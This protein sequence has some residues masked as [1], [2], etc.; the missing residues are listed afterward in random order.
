[1]PSVTYDRQ[2]FFVD[3][4]RFWVLGASI[5]YSRVPPEL[6]ARRI[7]AARQAG[8]N[9][10][11][12]ACPWM[13]HEPRKGRFS[14]QGET[15]VRRFVQTCGE[16][17]MRVILR[18]GPYVGSQFDGGGLPSWLM[19]LPNVAAREA[20][21]PFLERVARY[22]R[23]LF[24]ELSDLQATKGQP[25]LLVQSEHAWLCSHPRQAERYLREITRIIRESGINVPIISAN[26][27]WPEPDGT[28]DTWRGW[29]DLLV[30]LRQLRTVQ[31]AAPRLV[32]AFD[33]AG[34]DTW[35]VPHRHRKTASEVM[36]RLA[37]VLA[38]GAQVVVSPFHGGTNFGF[39]AGRVAGRSDGFVTTAAAAGAPLGE[40]GARGEKYYAVR[41]LM[42]FANHFSH[43]FAE[44][45]PDYHP[46]ALDLAELAAGPAGGGR[47][48]AKPRPRGVSIVSQSGSQG[49][50]VF[51]FGDGRLRSTALLLEDGIRMPVFFGDQPV[52][53][54]VFGV[55]LRGAGRLDYANLC[56]WAIVGRSIVVLYGPQRTGVFLSVNGAPLEATVP[57]GGKPL[58]LEH[59]GVTFVMCN[60]QQIDQTYHDDESVYV[61][62]GGID[63]SGAPIPLG[64][65]SEKAWVIGTGGRIES[66]DLGPPGGGR[67]S[68]RRGSARGA[69]RSTAFREWEAASAL[70][71]AR[72]ESPRYATLD[73]PETLT[74]CGAAAGYGW[75]RIQIKSGS[76]RKRLC[77][78]PHGGDR[79]HFFVDGEL[80]RVFGVGPGA[81]HEPFEL[82][83]SKGQ[84]TIVVLAESLGRFAEG[85]D[86]A[87]R[88]G[89]YG[90]LYEVKRLRTIRPKIGEGDPVDPFVLRGYLAHRASG[91][92]SDTTQVKWTFVHTRKTPILVDIDGAA[93]SGTFVLN[94]QPVAYYAGATGGC[95]ARLLL[96][97][98]GT[99]AFRRGRNVLRFAPDPRQPGAPEEL[100]KATAIYE[101]TETLTKA[102]SWGF[103][104]W[105]A[106]AAS[107][108]SPLGKAAAK[109]VKG[110]PCWWRTSFRTPRTELPAWLDTAGL[111]KGQAYVNGHLLG[112]YFTATAEGRPVGPQRR[113]YVPHV[114]LDDEQPNELLIFD[115][116]GF[117]P[118]RTSLVLRET[119][120]GE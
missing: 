67:G 1:M 15:D 10:I 38:A 76:A 113:L 51:V 12:T 36:Q 120:D 60:Q 42:T 114:W 26:D 82:R 101:C 45:D 78:V 75:Y 27:L 29:D 2:S 17:G 28:I 104:K 57:S 64:D 89:L 110:V 69:S 59:K 54:C 77:H 61:G 65:S 92:L 21:E 68:S 9:T 91:Q 20:N 108:F 71:H 63:A 79:L 39:L 102:A 7:A 48:A 22:F 118:Y 103:A 55:D 74:A 100:A 43:L 49:R 106:P 94:D 95:L 85:N 88:N 11:E 30:H 18:P 66:L 96:D 4:R 35:G 99:P 34:F 83:L 47:G 13:V 70:A 112:R 19:E 52:V 107:A 58:V 90:H 109:S 8:F 32:S 24:G 81:H 50:V 5:Q 6:W 115:E 117:D 40:A 41:R 111:S 33:P 37:Q 87:Q 3:G 46:V 14:F 97:R 44:L 56:P 62:V 72:G 86:L 80:E 53:W 84:S 73:G 25:I 23:K 93:A 16:A 119:G 116:H 105:E 31:P 98:E